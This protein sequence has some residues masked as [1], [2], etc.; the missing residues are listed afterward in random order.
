MEYNSPESYILYL[1]GKSSEEVKLFISIDD[2]RAKMVSCQEQKHKYLSNQLSSPEVF[3]KKL[4]NTSPAIESLSDK[5]VTWPNVNLR[6]ERF[7]RH[8][9]SVTL[10]PNHLTDRTKRKI[11]AL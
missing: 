3:L 4:M 10:Q 2:T 9:C 11:W 1:Y 7:A 5:R 6:T 8:L